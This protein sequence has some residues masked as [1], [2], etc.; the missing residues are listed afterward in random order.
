SQP[1]FKE[2]IKQV[3]LNARRLAEILKSKGYKIISGGTDN[4]LMLIDTVESLGLSGN[5]AGLALEKA[6]ITINKN[7][8]PNDPRKPW[9][10]SGIRIGTPAVTTRGMK[11]KEMDKI[12]DFIDQVLRNDQDNDL[13][14]D[15]KS[16]VKKFT[17]SFTIPGIK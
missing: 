13:L 17:S 3:I 1:E 6:N 10:P 7:T 14:F 16:E 2:Y 4:H 15:I 11:E 5:E 9:D 12:A 8:I